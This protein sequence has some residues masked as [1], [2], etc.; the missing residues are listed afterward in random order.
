[1]PLELNRPPRLRDNTNAALF[2]ASDESEYISGV[3]LPTA[4]GGILTDFHL[5]RGP[6]RL[7]PNKENPMLDPQRN[8]RWKTALVA[9]AAGLALTGCA[10]ATDTADGASLSASTFSELREG[11]INVEPASGDATSGGTLTFGAYSEP[12]SLDPAETIAAVTTGGVEMLNVYDSLMRFDAETATFV[13]QMAE[14]LDHDDDYRT[15]TLTLRDDVTFSNGDPVDAAAVRSSQE[16][17]ARS[18]GPESSL[19]IDNVREVS[20]PDTRTVVYRLDNPWPEFP[21]ILATGPGMIVAAAADGPDGSFTPIGAGP[22]TL[23][24]WAPTTEIVLAAN[25]T[26]WAGQPHLDALKIVYL[27][28]QQTNIDTLRTGGIDASFVRE[29]DHVEDVLS[30]GTS[31]YVNLAAAQNAAI[32]NTAEGR[33]GA[34]PRVRRAMQLAIDAPQMT[35]RI[36]NGYGLG[37]STLFP[38]YSRWHTETSGLAYDPEAARALLDAAKA[39][40]YD[41]KVEYIKANTPTDQRSALTF[42][43]MLEAVGFDVQVNIVP[44]VNDQIRLVAADR[45]YDVSGWGL[46]FRESDPYPKMFA[47]MSSGGTQTYGMYTSP[48]MDALLA[49]FQQEADLDAKRATMDRIQQQ[50]NQDVPFLVYGPFAEFVVWNDSVHGVV[51]SANTMVFF[52]GAWKD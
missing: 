51:G 16:R 22:F 50:I 32:I 46:A 31:G 28:G 47:T 38:E 48:E 26:Y 40:G 37:D 6:V 9:A 23:E 15:W 41:G 36:Y 17:Y 5:D 44:T 29:P 34:D 35:D 13:P 25:D 43:A 49:E 19:W 18:K 12:R 20:T 3:C 8:P 1:M 21:G 4:D 30:D 39:D 2:F 11:M 33:P 10:S 14:S 42:E 52:G 24:R 27:S 7:S 45:N